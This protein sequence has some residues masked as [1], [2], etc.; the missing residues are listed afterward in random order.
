MIKNSMREILSNIETNMIGEQMQEEIEEA[1]LKLPQAKH[2]IRF[3]ELLKEI[4]EKL[5]IK[6]LA[7]ALSADYSF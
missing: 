7:L 2:R 4:L 1:K 6:N 5:F 3:D